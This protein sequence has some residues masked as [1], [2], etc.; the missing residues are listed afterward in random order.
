[1][2]QIT[3]GQDSFLDIV[4][5]LVG[6]LIILVVLVG[7]Q[8]TASSQVEVE[9]DDSLLRQAAKLSSQIEEGELQLSKYQVDNQRQEKLIQQE[10]LLTASLAE[11][12]HQMLIQLE[13]V[14]REIE[15]E[16]SRRA[17]DEAERLSEIDKVKAENLKKQREFEAEKRA[18]IVR[19]KE[20]EKELAAVTVAEKPTRTKEIKHYPSPIA[21]TVF[22]DEVHFRLQNGR[23]SYVPMEELIAAMKA[24]WKVKA[25]KLKQTYRTVETIGPIQSNRLQYELLAENESEQTQV[26]RVNR[27]R[28]RFKQFQII[29]VSSDSGELI[30]AALQNDH[31]KFQTVLQRFEPRRTTVSVWVY[32]DSFQ[33]H[34]Q[35]K[36]WLHERGFQIASW[37]LGEG[38]LISGGPNG[39]KTS[40]Q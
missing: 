23:L 19:Q 35:L 16:K 18:L 7:A 31:S 29:P 8:A 38:K 40:A 5:N 30:D 27:K 4:A 37:P 33:Q 6:I 26:G 28:V 12:R 9:A 11:R 3:T 2:K 36:E 10:S 13:I 39:F 14:K 34:G 15:T 25:E 17:K 24:E 22:S 1:M 21:K 20:L 32:P